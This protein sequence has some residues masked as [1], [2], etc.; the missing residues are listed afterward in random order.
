VPLRTVAAVGGAY[1]DEVPPQH[2]IARIE[3]VARD[4]GVLAR[5]IE[6]YAGADARRTLLYWQSEL[7]AAVAELT[8]ARAS[9]RDVP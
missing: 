1:A 5:E 8:T 4:L 2:P 9:R 6:E 3:Q 7:R